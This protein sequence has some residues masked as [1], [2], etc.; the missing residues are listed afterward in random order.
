[1]S[2]CNVTVTN[3]THYPKVT[4]SFDIEEKD[5]P[6]VTTTCRFHFPSVEIIDNETGEIIFTYYNSRQQFYPSRVR[7]FLNNIDSYIIKPEVQ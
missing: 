6:V 2:T 5:I 1:M 3:L 7:N 4:L